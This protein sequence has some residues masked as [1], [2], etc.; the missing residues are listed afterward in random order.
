M[1]GEHIANLGQSAATNFL[2]QKKI[3]HDGVTDTWLYGSGDSGGGVTNPDGSFVTLFAYNH[4]FGNP[5]TSGGTL[6]LGGL[7]YKENR[8]NKVRIERRWVRRVFSGA[9]DIAAGGGLLV[10]NP[11]V[12]EEYTSLLDDNGNVSKMSA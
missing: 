11:V 3:E 9:Y 5:S 4:Y 6:G 7:V 10:F 2:T 8:S 12:T 1:D